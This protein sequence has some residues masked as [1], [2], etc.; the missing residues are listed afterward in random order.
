MRIRAT[1]EVKCPS[2]DYR[3]SEEI[4]ADSNEEFG[5]AIRATIKRHVGE[6]SPHEGEPLQ[7]NVTIIEP[8]QP[9]ATEDKCEAPQQ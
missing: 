6:H 8:K 4:T 9:E 5:P 1:L 7:A 3:A 2:C